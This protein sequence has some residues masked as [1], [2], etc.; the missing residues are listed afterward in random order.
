[1]ST[2]EKKLSIS[3]GSALLFL[4]INLPKTYNITSNILSLNLY[5]DNCPTNMGLIIHTI[6]FF[7]ITYLSMSN[8]YIKYGI[9]LKHTIYGSLLFYLISS[10][11]MFS[12][13]NSILGNKYANVN[14][15][16]TI[17][18]IVLHALI[19]CSALIGVMYLP[20]ENK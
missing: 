17:I 8:P 19:Y 13:I 15:C 5:N 16:P 10:P 7:I 2:F 18:G 1:M 20:E 14:G 11:P 6:L 4:L 12:L 3:I 9:K